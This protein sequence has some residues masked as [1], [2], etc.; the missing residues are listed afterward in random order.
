MIFGILVYKGDLFDRLETPLYKSLKMYEDNPTG[1][2]D[3]KVKKEAFKNIW[4]T[5]QMEVNRN[6]LNIKLTITHEIIMM[7][8]FPSR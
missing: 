3:Q 2:D 4:N 7:I 6:K 8:L 1:T 5:V